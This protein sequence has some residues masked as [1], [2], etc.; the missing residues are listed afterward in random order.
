MNIGSGSGNFPDPDPSD[1]KRRDPTRSGSATLVINVCWMLNFNRFFFIVQ[2][3]RSAVFFLYFIKQEI[4]GIYWKAE[5]FC[6]DDERP[7]RCPLNYLATCIFN[8]TL[9][10]FLQ[11]SENRKKKMFPKPTSLSMYAKVGRGGQR[12]ADLSEK[13]GIL[14]HLPFNLSFH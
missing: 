6:N 10:F 8:L 9:S 14:L 3:L 7:L 13:I 1:P 12:F 5:Q 2:I 4:F 11:N